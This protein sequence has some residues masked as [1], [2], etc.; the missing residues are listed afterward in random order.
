M[1]YYSAGFHSLLEEDFETRLVSS[2]VIPPGLVGTMYEIGPS[3][4]EIGDRAVGHWLDGFA[5]VSSVE[6]AP[7]TIIFRRRF[8]ATNWYRQALI[9]DAPSSWGFDSG[10]SYRNRHSAGDNTN[11]N[12]I[13]WRG[14][15]E[16]LGDTP[17]SV[18]IDAA[19]LITDRTQR[20]TGIVRGMDRN[21]ICSPHPVV[22]Q[23]TGERFD[24]SLFSGDPPGYIITV[25]D[26]EGRT[27][28][29]CHVPSPRLGY[30]H[31]FSVTARWVVLIE[32]PFTA[33]PRSLSRMRRPFL[34]NFVWDAARGTR[35]FVVDRKTGSL[36]TTFATR[37][38]F[39]LHHINAWDDETRIIVDLAAYAD[40]SILGR[41]AFDRG[42]MP[43]GSFPCP[44][45][46][47][48]TIDLVQK[49]VSC[50]SLKCPPGEFCSVDARF[51][52]RPYTVFFATGPARTGEPADRLCRSD[53]ATGLCTPWSADECMP[54]ASVFVPEAADSPEGSGWL[55]SMVRDARQKRSFLIILNSVSMTEEA[56][57]WLPHALPF[58]LHTIFISGERAS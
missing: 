7:H 33:H 51:A 21:V 11:M 57:I 35:I 56:R 6:I 26:S 1:S 20:R 38:L 14:Q 19:T 17:Q 49:S 12:M 28:R 41:L 15:M 40:P 55:L 25:T 47:R 48:L 4:F 50:T 2:G 29:L 13:L 23:N 42:S 5:A 32:T 34:R 3:R 46:T 16:L 53:I 24:L 44:L 31:S 10:L 30:I 54:G 37:P 9:N 27:R 36:R 39:V 52:M 45:A 22:D 8:A 18:T 43:S 58:G